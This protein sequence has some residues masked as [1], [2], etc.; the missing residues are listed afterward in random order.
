MS[1]KLIQQFLATVDSSDLEGSFEAA[2]SRLQKLKAFYEERYVN[3][4][5]VMDIEHPEYHGAPFKNKTVQFKK[6]YIEFCQKQY[7]DGYELQV[8]GEREPIP[9]EIEALKD[10]AAREQALQDEYD[11]KQ[12]EALSKKFS[13]KKN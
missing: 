10:K 8:W 5:V 4:P 6:V 13:K 3:N 12:F 7:D 2:I 9:E 11:K 1:N